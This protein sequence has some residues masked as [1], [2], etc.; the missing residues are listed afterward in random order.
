MVL[1]KY[2]QAELDDFTSG[3]IRFPLRNLSVGKHTLKLKAWDVANNSSE[4]EI[5]F[6]VSGGFVIEEVRNYPNPVNDYTFFTFKHNQSDATLNTIIEV[7]DQS[8]RRIQLLREQIG[9]NGLN[10]NPVRW[11]L[12]AS[13]LT[14][15]SG[16]YIYR[17]S[18]ENN[19]GVIAS[20]SGKIIIAR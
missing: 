3:S 13:N 7:F 4:A 10:S 8:G 18:A 1:N 17:V 12:S 14:L 19:D 6:V 16:M 9:S 11:D 20:K 5:E 2:Y 15:R